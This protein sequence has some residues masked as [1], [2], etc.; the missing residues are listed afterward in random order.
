M[1]TAREPPCC[2]R[3]L[4]RWGSLHYETQLRIVT[5]LAILRLRSRR[6]TVELVRVCA[7]RGDLPFVVWGLPRSD[8]SRRRPL[9]CQGRSF[10]PTSQSVGAS[11][12]IRS[13]SVHAQ[14][15]NDPDER[16]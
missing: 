15:A 6:P 2:F 7:T 16:I 14:F 11:R 9:G 4:G 10:C 8:P 3:E 12:P 1:R 13:A 5:A